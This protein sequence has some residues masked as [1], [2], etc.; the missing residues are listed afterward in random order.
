MECGVDVHLV[1][2]SEFERVVAE[3][4]LDRKGSFPFMSQFS[5]SSVSW[6]KVP[7]VE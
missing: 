4:G 3:F 7:I 2:E 6:I 1:W 5:R